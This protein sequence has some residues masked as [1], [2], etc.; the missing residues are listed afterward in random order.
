MLDAPR[1]V[2]KGEEL[3]V[4]RLRAYLEE[5][6]IARGPLEVLQFPGG[7]SNLTYSVRVGGAT[8]GSI[9]GGQPPAGDREMVLRRPPFGNRVKTAHDMGR[10]VRVLSRLCEVYPPA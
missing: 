5:K 10:E 6:N 7:H 8:R 4:E 9:G 1:A 3:D 2:R